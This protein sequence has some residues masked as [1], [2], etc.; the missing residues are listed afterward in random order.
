MER[1]AGGDEEE[2]VSMAIVVYRGGGR[3]GQMDEEPFI[4]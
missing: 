4:K 3:T 1:E 2:V